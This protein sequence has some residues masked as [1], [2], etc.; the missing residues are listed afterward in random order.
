MGLI[1]FA[2]FTLAIVAIVALARR[3][4]V[5]NDNI[6]G[7]PE[8]PVP[9]PQPTPSSPQGPLVYEWLVRKKPRSLWDRIH[10]RPVEWEW[11]RNPKWEA[12]HPNDPRSP[13]PTEPPSQDGWL[14]Y[15]SRIRAQQQAQ[16]PTPAPQAPAAAAL[17]NPAP[18]QAQPA[19]TPPPQQAAASS[20]TP[21][22]TSRVQPSVAIKASPG[23]THVKVDGIEFDLDDTSNTTNPS[24]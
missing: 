14:H 2:V 4:E 24:P 20:P 7:I 9:D 16:Q 3:G 23:V 8:Y 13:E 10:R 21:R 12:L 15:A 22:R 6:V 19:Q 18:T 17:P 11:Y 1:V 5:Y